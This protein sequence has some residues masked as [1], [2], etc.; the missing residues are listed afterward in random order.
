MV[1]SVGRDVLLSDQGRDLNAGDIQGIKQTEILD[2][3]LHMQED[4]DNVAQVANKV[5]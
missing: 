2:Y 3:I 1:E 4:E 5:Y